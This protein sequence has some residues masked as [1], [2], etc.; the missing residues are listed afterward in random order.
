[1]MV[2]IVAL[3]AYI[4]LGIGVAK[5]IKRCDIGFS[6]PGDCA[7]LVVFWPIAVTCMSLFG[8]WKE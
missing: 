8:D 3:I 6:E 1:M 5:S 4:L 2:I 7:I